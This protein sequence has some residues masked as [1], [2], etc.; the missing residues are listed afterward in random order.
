MALPNS[1]DKSTPAAGTA[2]GL[3]DDQIRAL[4]LFLQDVFGIPDA[5]S[6]TASPMTIAAAGTV[7]VLQDFTW[8]DNVKVTL[9]TGGDWDV[10]SDGTDLILDRVVGS[11]VIRIPDTL[12][13]LL[14]DTANSKMTT[15]ITI[16]QGAA[17]DEALALKSSD[18]DQ[19]TTNEAESDTYGVFKKASGADGGLAIV[20]FSDGSFGLDLQ[21]IV[22]TEQTTDVGSSTGAIRL[23]AQKNNAGLAVAMGTTGNVLTI[24]NGTESV[25]LMKGDGKLHIKS[26][27]STVPGGNQYY[28]T[29]GLDE[30]DDV[31]LIRAYERMRAH[32]L[33]IIMSKWDEKVRANSDDLKRVGVLSSQGDFICIQ[34]M[35]SLLGGAIWQEHVQ[36]LDWQAKIEQKLLTLEAK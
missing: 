2:L 9:G 27:E 1:I 6:I 15:G 18:V 35:H 20:G 21:A 17:D 29:V 4:K 14:N 25:F 13:F 3:G 33:G 24:H 12:L 22:A 32:D 11:G 5:T 34:R 30:E 26:T 7:T 28:E 10:Y 31:A 23:V 36:R 16:N 8:N 19:P